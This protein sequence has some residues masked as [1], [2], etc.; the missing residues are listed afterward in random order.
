[1]KKL[2]LWELM[3]RVDLNLPPFDLQWPPVTSNDLRCQTYIVFLFCGSHMRI[4]TKNNPPWVVLLKF[5]IQLCG[6]IV[7]KTII[8]SRGGGRVYNDFWKNYFCFV[9]FSYDLINTF[10]T[11]EFAKK[12][13]A[14]LSLP[15]LKV[16][17]FWRYKAISKSSVYS[18]S[19][20][21]YW[22]H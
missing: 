15:L 16:Y 6:K 20:S 13:K 11:L 3:L 4:L 19:W 10:T 1:M 17:Y 21:Y 14:V 12:R 18:F 5:Y 7:W 9:F 8:F 22:S 2:Y